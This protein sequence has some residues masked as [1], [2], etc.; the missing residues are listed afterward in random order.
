MKCTQLGD[1]FSRSPLQQLYVR[2]L[3]NV[4]CRERICISSF[5]DASQ[6]LIPMDGILHVQMKNKHSVSSKHPMDRILQTLWR[7]CHPMDGKM[8]TTS[9][10]FT[11]QPQLCHRKHCSL[12]HH[13]CFRALINLQPRRPRC[14]SARATGIPVAP[15]TDSKQ[16][17]TF[18]ALLTLPRTSSLA[19]PQDP[20]PSC[21]ILTFRRLS[22]AHHTRAFF[23]SGDYSTVLLWMNSTRF[24]LQENFITTFTFSPAVYFC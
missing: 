1:H 15:T 14:S 6:V 16:L 5:A 12:Q 23:S 18:C 20:S 13:P 24:N 11:D 19:L 10:A 22:F 7:R 17:P 4:L 21:S 8:K 9:S 2:V 3:Q